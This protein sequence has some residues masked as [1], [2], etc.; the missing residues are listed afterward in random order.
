[1]DY[2]PYRRT[3]QGKNIKLVGYSLVQADKPWYNYFIPPS[4]VH[5]LLSMKYFVLNFAIAGKG[6]IFSIT[7]LTLEINISMDH[8]FEF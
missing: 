2:L 4:T 7:S 8:I 1:M 5:T 3:H 6:S